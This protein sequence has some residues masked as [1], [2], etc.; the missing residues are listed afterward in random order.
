MFKQAVNGENAA[1]GLNLDK[2][3]VSLI[4]K[5]NLNMRKMSAKVPASILKDEPELEK[6]EFS[7]DHSFKRNCEKPAYM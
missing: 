3:T 6:F 5:E 2:E 7:S 4:L 1:E